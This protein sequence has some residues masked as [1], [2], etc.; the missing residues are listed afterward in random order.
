V[1]KLSI[2]TL[3]SRCVNNLRKDRRAKRSAARQT[4]RQPQ[5]ALAA[6][7]E[8]SLVICTPR[9]ARGSILR[10]CKHLR[11]VPTPPH[12]ET[13]ANKGSICRYNMLN[14]LLKDSP[15]RARERCT[16]NQVRGRCLLRTSPLRRSRKFATRKQPQATAKI[17]CLDD[18]PSVVSGHTTLR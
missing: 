3:L 10:D 12:R 1:V 5:R 15:L 9:E 17:R 2:V 7:P 13:V 11:R 18:V 8:R 6:I 16:F 4:L 14:S